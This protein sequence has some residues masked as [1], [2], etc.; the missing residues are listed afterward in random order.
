MRLWR[1][2]LLAAL[3]QRSCASHVNAGAVFVSR[4]L[5]KTALGGTG[6]LPRVFACGAMEPS[7]SSS[8]RAVV[9]LVAYALLWG[10]GTAGAARGPE[11]HITTAPLQDRRPMV[12]GPTSMAAARIVAGL[13]DASFPDWLAAPTWVVLGKEAF[14]NGAIHTFTFV[15]RDGQGGQA[16]S[17]PLAQDESTLLAGR[18]QFGGPDRVVVLQWHG[19]AVSGRERAILRGTIDKHPEW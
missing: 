16:P 1:R 9:C 11:L 6:T 10:A 5:V 19:R 14:P 13:L 4:R 18:V 15:I 3:V 12:P 7:R 17:N 2:V 8:R